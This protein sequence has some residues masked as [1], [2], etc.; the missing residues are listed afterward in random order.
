MFSLQ[1]VNRFGES[2][3]RKRP[4]TQNP[5]PGSYDLNRDFGFSKHGAIGFEEREIGIV[6]KGVPGPAFYKSEVEPKKISF[7]LNTEN[8]WIG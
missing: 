5:G 1:D 4:Q 2:N 7:M 6:K 8:K 3:R